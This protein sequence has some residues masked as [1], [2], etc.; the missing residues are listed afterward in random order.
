VRLVGVHAGSLEAA[1]GQMSLLESERQER[2]RKALEAVDKI[3]D[4]FGESSV[5]IASGMQGDYAERVHE[6]PEGLPGKGPAKR[7]EP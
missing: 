6:N 2:W 7:G 1:E 5:S 3:R 4:R